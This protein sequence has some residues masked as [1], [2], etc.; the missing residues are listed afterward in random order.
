[1]R[2]L[3]MCVALCCFGLSLLASAKADDT[4][5]KW[6]RIKLE[7]VFRA[8]GVAVADINKDG[9]LDLVNGEAWYENPLG[10]RDPKR[11]PFA[12]ALYKSGSW[13]MH[14]LRAEGI[15]G[16]IAD[17][18]Y[19][20]NF[21]LW[22][23]DISGDGWQD[24]IVIGFPGEPCHWFENP[25]GKPGPWNKSEIWHSAANETPQFQDITG[26]GKPEL[27]MSSET[28]QMMGYLEIPAPAQAKKKWDYT[29]VNAEKLGPQLGHRYYHGLGIGDV[30]RDG[31][32]DIIIPHGWWEQP[33]KLND[34]P[35][36]FHKHILK[37]DGEGAPET[38]ADIYVDD[39]DGDGDNDILMSAAHHIGVWWFEN[40]GGSPDPKFKQHIID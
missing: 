4:P 27:I 35:W 36:T 33:A 21:A 20:N 28:E 31:R 29:Q 19:S 10:E 1:M 8:E 12:K 38:A 23:Y 2:R 6:E 26:D 9:H 18:S 40:V 15:R 5:V 17:G 16:T 30:N 13:T 11:A 24:V 32:K 34:G 7:E 14:P 3:S 37:G 25:Q 22:T 39:L